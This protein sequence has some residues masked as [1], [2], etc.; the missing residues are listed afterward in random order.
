M[1]DKIN[2]NDL[3]FEPKGNYKRKVNEA[4]DK[5]RIKIHEANEKQDVIPS[6]IGFIEDLEKAQQ[7]FTI[8]LVK[9]LTDEL[10]KDR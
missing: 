1:S 9:K 7:E 2:I 4:S 5:M 6:L 10:N 8:E 3:T